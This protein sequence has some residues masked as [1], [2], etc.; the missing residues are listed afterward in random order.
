MT[1]FIQRFNGKRNHKNGFHNTK[2]L[3]KKCDLYIDHEGFVGNQTNP[4]TIY[5]RSSNAK[6]AIQFLKT[7]QTPFILISGSDDT[8]F[9]DYISEQ[10]VNCLINNKFCKKI[11]SENCNINEKVLNLPTGMYHDIEVVNYLEKRHN[12]TDEPIKKKFK[13]FCQFNNT[14]PFREKSKK[15]S[16]SSDLCD[17]FEPVLVTPSNTEIRYKS[18]KMMESYCFTLCPRGNGIDT[19]RLF[20]ALALKSIPIVESS[21]IDDIHYMLPI[22]IVNNWEELNE[23]FLKNEL[24]RLNM[25]YQGVMDCITM[26][27]WW[28]YITNP[29]IFISGSCRILTPISRHHP[30]SN[31]IHGMYKNHFGYN[32]VTMCHDIN[33][34]LQFVKH[35]YN[36]LEIPDEILKYTYDCYAYKFDS[37]LQERESH[38]KYEKHPESNLKTIQNL[39]QSVDMFILEICSLKFYTHLD[40]FVRSERCSKA[41]ENEDNDG[42]V[43][44]KLCQ[45]R[46]IIPNYKKLVLVSHLRPN[47]YRN[48]N[49]IR[50]RE[51]IHKICEEFCSVNNNCYHYDPSIIVAKIKKQKNIFIV[52]DDDWHYK[53]EYLKYI[54]DDL[55]NILY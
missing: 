2:S 53:D 49:I 25:K 21:I 46:R 14:H 20:E 54:Y 27:F 35:C 36:E 29:T 19:H 8:S 51:T 24:E 28:N 3:V 30:K 12:I 42:N 15:F 4:K 6:Y 43:R 32:H 13:I 52:K 9:L 16:I 44:N 41:I 55:Q 11:F 34:Q 45:L 26:D 38:V 37:K 10:D 5:I 40:F 23:T 18:L 1:I 47:I 31:T 17:F 7:L 22:I 48:G 33:Q 50:S 39:I